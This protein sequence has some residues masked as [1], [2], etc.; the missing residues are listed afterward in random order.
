MSMKFIS[1][2][3]LDKMLSDP[4]SFQLIDV[5]EPYEYE[6][7]N[8]GGD[9]IP[10]DT[11]LSSTEKISTDKKVVFCCMS[12]KRSSAMTH[13]LERKFGMKNLYSLQGGLEGYLESKQ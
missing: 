8:L 4:S 5:R 6:D 2:E 1:V 10:L 3:E 12:G 7:W 13:T 11:V 9:N